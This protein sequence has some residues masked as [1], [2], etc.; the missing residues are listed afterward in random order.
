[1]FVTNLRVFVGS[2]DRM[3]DDGAGQLLAIESFIQHP[4]Y[5]TTTGYP[6]DIAI[7]TFTGPADTSGPNVQNAILP[8]DNS[9]DFV[10][11]PCFMS[12]WGSTVPGSNQLS[13]TLQ[14]VQ[15]PTINNTYCENLLAGIDD[16]VPFDSSLCSYSAPTLDTGA[17]NG[18]AGGPVS[19]YPSATDTSV[20]LAAGV[21]SY[22][23]TTQGNC[24]TRYPTV[25]LRV[26]YYLPWISTIVPFP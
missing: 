15:I 23:V 19:C 11:S 10:A 20:L 9:N 17:C 26:G 16:A 24:D 1:M 22:I 6:N 12:G 25:S 5:T 13:P 3:N 2:L 4:N 8:E 14:F 7:L 18:D 21:M